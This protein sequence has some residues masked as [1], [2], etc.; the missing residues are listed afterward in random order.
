MAPKPVRSIERLS[1]EEESVTVT[2][3]GDALRVLRNLQTELKV[4][5]EEEVVLRGVQLLLSAVGKE[6]VLRD[7]NRSELIRL[8]G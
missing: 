3:T 5:N 2:F 4:A 1:G 7:S 6:V 8:W